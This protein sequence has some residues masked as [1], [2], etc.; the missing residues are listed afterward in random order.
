MKH[1]GPIELF[2]LL[3]AAVAPCLGQPEAAVVLVVATCLWPL[4]RPPRREL[5]LA[6]PALL[7]A[8]G[9][10][11][12][13]LPQVSLGE[14][15]P[16][17][18][19]ARAEPRYEG[20]WQRLE[21]PAGAAR[22]AL[23]ADPST[24]ESRPRAFEILV[25]EA[26]RAGGTHLLLLDPDGEAIAWAGDG[27]LHEVGAERLPAAGRTHLASFSAVTLLVVQPLSQE[28][29]PWRIV[30][31]HTY[32]NHP[33]PF[34]APGRAR[35][36]A[37][38]WSLATALPAPASSTGGSA[39]GAGEGLRVVRA[40]EGP[41]ML[42]QR[43]PP[44]APSAIFAR[45]FHR[46]SLA[47]VGLA[48]LALAVLRGV[49]LA[50]RTV[51][52]RAESPLA[53]S[54]S[55]KYR[56]RGA[57]PGSTPVAL[58]GLAGCG[59][60]ALAAT[61]SPAATAALLL[62][63]ALALYA[64]GGAGAHRGGGSMPLTEAL[65]AGVLLVTAC[66][67]LQVIL[68]TP[69]DLAAELLASPAVVCLRLALW[70]AALGLLLLVAREEEL[71]GPDAGDRWAWGG[72][73]LLLAA[74]A[75][76]DRP[77]VALPLFAAGFAAAALWAQPRR[78]IRGPGALAAAVLLAAVSSATAWETAYRWQLRQHLEADL[79]S[80]MAPPS[81]TQLDRVQRD[82]E[83]FFAAQDLT[84]LTPHRG[85]GLERQ[86]LAYVL[87][88]RS[89]LAQPNALSAVLV[90]PLVGEASSFTLGLTLEEELER[91]EL[92]PERSSLPRWDG[93]EVRGRAQ[94]QSRG[95]PWGEVLFWLRP[96]P[97][98]G[99]HRPA[100]SGPIA[101]TEIVTALLSADTGAGGTVGGLPAPV[102]Y[103][104]YASSGR[105][106]LT[107]WDEAPP[108]PEE[109]RSDQ[110]GEAVVETPLGTARAY[111]RLGLDGWEVLFLPILGPVEGLD[112]MGT[113]AVAVL[114]LLALGALVLVLLALPRPAFRQL[115]HRLL[116]SYSQRL[117]IV[118]TLFAL[119]P[120]PLL[121]LTLV[122][123]V[124]KRL[125]LQ[126]RDAGEAVLVSAQRYLGGYLR[127]LPA[128]FIIDLNLFEER[129][130]WLST[131]VRHDLNLYWGPGEGQI[132][133]SR[134][135]L[136]TAGLLP[137]RIP[138]EVYARL[139]LGGFNLSSRTHQVAS[140]PYV[141]L[142]SPLRIPGEPVGQ[143]RLFLSMPLL[144]QQQRAAEQLAD[145]RRQALLFSTAL[146]VLLVA[147]STRLARGFT[148]PITELVAGTRRIAHGA[149]SLEMTPSDLELAAVVDAV[150]DMARR[151]AEGR[152]RLV[153]EK[154][155]VERIV[156]HITSG[157]VSLDRR[158]RVL[159]R[160]RVAAELLG[161]EVGEP[162]EEALRR[163]PPLEP[164]AEA[165]ARR[166]EGMSG[167]PAT[168]RLAG[169]EGQE[170]EWSL[171]LVEVPGSGEP[172]S[173]L[174]V[175]DVTE[176]LRGQ[177]LQAWAEMARIIAHEIKNPLTP[178]R[179][180]AEH[181]QL[182]HGHDP[183]QFDAVFERCNRNILR[184]VDELQQI[185][186]EFS[187]YSSLLRIDP[188][189]GDLRQTVEE[190]AE[191][192]RAAPPPGV[193]VT[194]DA[195]PEPLEARFDARLLGRAVRNLLENA[196]RASAGGGRVE[197][198]LEAANGDARI[199]VS[200]TGPGV[201]PALLGRIFDPYFSTHDT[202]TGLGLPIARRVAEEHG[203]TIVARNRP[204]G[205]LEV[206][207]TIPLS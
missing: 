1:R 101:T 73:L 199:T 142:Y 172:S 86:D 69:L 151:I 17:I 206:G 143:E 133:S 150:D 149:T 30:A 177:R 88:R 4:T 147:V 105:A 58:T 136:F 204:G 79:L 52:L 181:M 89:P 137:K 47:A 51:S 44:A 145:L 148:K 76:H 82:L 112:R 104:L 163:S 160:N 202:G 107:P 171:V 131:V 18:W 144:D 182:V 46:W 152:Q 139:A 53:V 189:R 13:D 83:T 180:S 16:E 176:V 117:L 114:G 8:A 126:Q 123:G 72:A 106:L 28:S 175:E 124:Q 19:S 50:M 184:Q 20:L 66:F 60:W 103:G 3:M 161:V 132:A 71:D 35:A 90:R 74:A 15:S 128:G 194:F 174:V 97:G 85:S 23:T 158:H 190:L 113:H 102:L 203:G 41:V 162:I 118:Y 170:K 54:G 193:E 155:V 198:G 22:A 186:S 56:M 37:Y 140:S 100:G 109:L 196:V 115:L 92:A 75:L 64:L 188:K 122:A 11:V 98:F 169:E 25:E 95:R 36:D 110:T 55:A 167:A 166:Q 81:A 62:G 192:Y 84:E 42:V 70:A 165:L 93:M 154:R 24:L 80:R 159:M 119:I 197:V 134:P 111:R 108:L 116:R 65:A 125:W 45:P 9:L 179:L 48:L 21:Q 61:A 40:E 205:G 10:L 178:I 191:S 27:L 157:V 168:V 183:E 32:P 200:D 153:Q 7:L 43:M 130:Q 29:R 49:G 57:P 156:E 187:T 6:G 77:W 38:R 201:D 129:L 173:L 59:C 14:L 120:L 121:N 135:E 2:L 31:G 26:A 39:D 207:I 91:A 12:A 63:S 127:D 33:L 141:E 94:L 87:W 34:A 146:L 67:G 68:D 138:G 96:R 195:P 5:W 99:L 78:V 164:V 185:A